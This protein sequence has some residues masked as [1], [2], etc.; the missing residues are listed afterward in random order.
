VHLAGVR[1]E[2]IRANNSHE[3]SRAALNNALGVPLES[4]YKL[5]SALTEASLPAAELAKYEREAV[6]IR[7]EARQA[8]LAGQIAGVQ[9][10]LARSAFFPQVVF[11]GALES[12]RGTFATRTGGNYV[13]A[14]SLRF[15]ILNGGADKARLEESAAALRR[16]DAERERAQ[17]G[18]RLEV[19][20]AFLDVRAAGQRVEVA[21]ASVTEAEE[22][23]RIMQNRYE[24]GLAT[25]TDLLRNETALL[26]AR[27]RRLAAVYD[28]RLAAVRLER[29]T[30]RL[31]PDSE[32]LNP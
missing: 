10:E 27:T 20:R 18:I 7:P 5:T 21:R 25:V 4:E 24:A 2:Q 22:S 8:F 26:A 28:Q 17:S 32:V 9:N 15:N 6:E 29:A 12:D 16:A 14:L 31:T 11:H 1:E 19:R 23:L 30:G 13:A 3:V